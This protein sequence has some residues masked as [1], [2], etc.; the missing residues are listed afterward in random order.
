MATRVLGVL[1]PEGAS[2]QEGPG[3]AGMLSCGICCLAASVVLNSYASL[4]ASISFA[5]E[6]DGHFLQA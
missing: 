2:S 5:V 1:V 3:S 4:L 6:E